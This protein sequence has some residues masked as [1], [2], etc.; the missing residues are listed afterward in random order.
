MRVIGIGAGGHARVLLEALAASPGIEVVGL[1]DAD[2][3]T[4]GKDVL[5][6][7]V[8]GG[9][10]MLPRLRREG[11]QHA[12]IAIGGTHDNQPRRRAYEL[13]RREGFELLNVVHPSAVVSPSATLGDGVAVCPAAVVGAG[14]RI[15]SDVI[16]NSGAIVEHDCVVGDHAHIA[17]G[18]VLAGGVLVGSG[19]HIGAGASVR[20]G[21][22]IGAGAVVAMGAVVVDDVSDDAVVA[23]VPARPMR[24]GMKA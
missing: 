21:L 11:V 10:E 2:P 9:D 7:K 8:L 12:F 23:G 15:G 6:V 22:R 20:Q 13:A 5:G 16:V 4:R 3:E 17:S 14:A 1:L 18:A 24:A 19:A